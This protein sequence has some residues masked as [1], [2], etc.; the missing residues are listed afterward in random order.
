MIY[1][2]DAQ[3]APSVRELSARLAEGSS[4]LRCK[5]VYTVRLQ[6]LRHGCAMPPAYASGLADGLKL[7]N[8][9]PRNHKNRLTIQQT[10][11]PQ[12]GQSTSVYTHFS[13]CTLAGMQGIRSSVPGMI[14][15]LVRPTQY[16][17][18]YRRSNTPMISKMAPKMPSLT[19]TFTRTLLKIAMSR[20]VWHNLTQNT[21]PATFYDTTKSPLPDAFLRRQG[22]KL[23]IT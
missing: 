10:S 7:H 16:Q 22:V 13:R 21:S 17:S 18:M 23:I 11:A 9:T 6:S 2:S 5:S 1:N 12:A 19:S 14:H 8:S 20:L 15:A 4:R 3:K